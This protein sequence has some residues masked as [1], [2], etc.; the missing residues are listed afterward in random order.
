MSLFLPP[1]VCALGY[2]LGWECL[3][4]AYVVNKNDSSDAMLF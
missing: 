2:E 4:Q 3:R 1:A